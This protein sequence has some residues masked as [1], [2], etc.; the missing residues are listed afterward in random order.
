MLLAVKKLL[1]E[2][3]LLVYSAYS[4]SSSLFWGDKIILSAGVQHGDPLDPL[5][6]C[7][8]L[9]NLISELTAELILGYLD[10]VTFGGSLA[11]VSRDVQLFEQ[12]S[13]QLGLK[14]NHA[15]TEVITNDP[16]I[17]S[18]D[19][20]LLLPN[21][22]FLDPRDATLLGSPMPQSP[23]RQGYSV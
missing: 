17:I 15:K 3:Y 6:F 10:D 1:P 4:S 14:L 2:L 13:K 20:L 16:S 18:S 22:Q 19:M 21:A 23:R 11:D 12:A 7:L 9:H 8:T 5:L